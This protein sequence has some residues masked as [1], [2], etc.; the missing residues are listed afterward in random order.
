MSTF[1]GNCQDT[2]GGAPARCAAC[3]AA[4]PPT[5]WPADRR[6]GQAVAGS[7]YRVL[8]RIGAGGF[9][10][11]YLVETVVGGLRRA[12]KVL[13]AES[14]ANVRARERFIDEAVTLERLNHPNIARCYAAGT[15]EEGEP[16]LLLELVEGVSVAELLRPRRSAAPRPLAPLR[17]ARIAK[18]IASGLVVAHANGIL[19]RDLKPENVLVSDPGTMDEQ[20]KLVDFGIARVLDQDV[21]TTRSALGTPLF[22]A[23]EQLEPGAALSAAVD[24]WQLGATLFL[25]L[26]GRAPH[27]ASNFGD[28][29]AHF[30]RTRETGPRP[31][32]LEP[33]LLACPPLDRLVSLLLASDRDRRPRSAAHVCAELARIEHLLAPGDSPDGALALLE[34]LC[35]RPGEDAWSAFC[36]YLSTLPPC[37]ESLVAAAEALLA[38]WPD[39]LRVAPIG[40]WEAAHRGEDCPTWPLVRALDLSGRGL[41]D[42]D[43][44]ELAS[45]RALRN[46]TWLNLAHNEIGN[47]GLSALAVSPHAASLR[48]LD[49]SHN[50]LS[51][52]VVAVLAS[53]TT[54]TRLAS[55]A[56]C[57]NGLGRLAADALAATRLPL[58]DLDLSDNALQTAGATALAGSPAL[59]RL[60]VLRLR[61][62]AIGSDGA[63]AI[64]TSPALSGLRELDLS[65]NQIGAAG[66]A[67]LALSGNVSSLQVLR[68]AG[69]N[70]GLHGLE[71]LLSSNR[72][73]A[74]ETLD[75]SSND[76]GAQGAM[77]LAS[78][79]F[80]R[81]L[82]ALHLRDNA[83]GDAGI[84]ALLGAP[85]MAGVRRLDVAQNGLTAAGARLLGGAPPELE[86]LDLSGNAF[87][88]AGADAL[89]TALPRLRLRWLHLGDCALGG[90]AVA[91]IMA[92]IP[93]GLE[94]LDVP[95]NGIDAGSLALGTWGDRRI[96]LKQLD[97]SRN[98]L[99]TGGLGALSR[100][101]ALRD[102]TALS[103]AGIAA[104]SRQASDL[105]SALEGFSALEALTLNDN[106]LGAP[107]AD[108]LAASP[109]SAR[110]VCL[111]LTSAHL[112]DA[113]L[114]AL[115]RGTAWHALRRL[116]LGRNDVSLG[117]AATLLASPAMALVCRLDLRHNAL[118]GLVDVHSLARRHVALLEA[119][120]ARIAS[121]HAD[122]AE[123]FYAHVF[124]RYP[125]IKPLFA[126]TSMRQQQQHLMASLAMAIDH[127]RN[128]DLATA[129]L[130]A[131]GA[132]HSGYGVFPSH[133]QAVTQA[134][135]DTIREL[136]GD[137]WTEDLET[138]WHDGIEA[139]AKTMM[140]A[141]GRA[142]APS[143]PR[144]CPV[145]GIAP[146]GDDSHVRVAG[147]G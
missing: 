109:L 37:P 9:G 111:S 73:G 123:R 100:S 119:S 69:N 117:A 26:T 8:R 127:M 59:A 74:L 81:R 144:A 94:R 11:V 53:S 51:S 142:E 78:S 113:G 104:S 124:S 92:A 7:Q 102:L 80:A 62:N 44:K 96:T 63:G 85:H 105:V 98:P 99:G 23:P 70:L 116:D 12:L 145:H 147:S 65:H 31:A 121:N 38:S 95:G 32:A 46:I 106:A 34:A 115:A 1:C 15:L 42:E 143:S 49:V 93:A 20:V 140:T 16:Y 29:M 68:L 43:V 130:Q 118:A 50:R 47:D 25:M 146:A 114:G 35:A 3:G 45:N 107:F 108:A 14:A 86:E 41:R 22:M 57:G 128:P 138:A 137:D 52:G 79:P 27:D 21:T 28:L 101:G 24:L 5:G 136:S 97:V 88:P 40:W 18:Q 76:I 10:T 84:A 90:A 71:L 87:G 39:A 48:H 110:L 61:D 141:H 66:A 132:R 112:G 17:A 67:T 131:L 75:L 83:L 6:I 125:S 30:A 126:R 133:Y 139:I 72:F 36:R 13:H 4:Q 60:R 91:R 2:L 134:L 129:H 54:L 122:F 58:Q 33:A 55:L 89:E 77:A 19:H 82:K 120:Y 64:A 56:L 135:L 103:A